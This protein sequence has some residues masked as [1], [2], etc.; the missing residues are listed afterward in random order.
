MKATPVPAELNVA[1]YLVQTRSEGAFWIR[2]E[3]RL[4]KIWGANKF[5]QPRETDCHNDL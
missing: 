4:E 3:G 2:I 1:D 5:S